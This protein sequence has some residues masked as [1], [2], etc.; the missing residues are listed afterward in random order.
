LWHIFCIITYTMRILIIED[1]KPSADRLCRMLRDIN[2]VECDV[3]AVASSNE[4]AKA[5]FAEN[6]PTPQ[7]IIA[8]IRLGD[9]LSFDALQLAPPHVPVIFATAYDQYAVNAFRY[10][11]IAYLLKPV[12]LQ[13][14][15]HALQ[16]VEE[17]E[18]DNVPFEA[19]L[20][21]TDQLRQLLSS[22]RDGGIRYRERFLISFRDE[23]KVVHVT[24]VS[25]I[26]LVEGNVY[27]YTNDGRQYFLSQRLEELETQLNPDRFM[28][29]NR[30]YIVCVDAVESMASHFLGKMRLRLHRYPNTDILVSRAKVPLVKKWLDS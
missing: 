13:E 6:H 14:L 21:D 25:H 17:R 15:A 23:M 12:D 10:N 5:W 29:V 18:L 2:D 4:E 7:L 16:K 19:T 22:L 20:S 26:G 11:G 1:E 3:V 24:E 27:L 28:R 30:Q 9:G 8:D